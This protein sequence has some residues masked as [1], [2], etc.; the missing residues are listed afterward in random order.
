MLVCS[1][2]SKPDG[3]TQFQIASL[4]KFRIPIT[5]AT[6]LFYMILP[7]ACR[8]RLYEPPATSRILYYTR[9]ALNVVPRLPPHHLQ[10]VCQQPPVYVY[11]YNLIC[12]VTRTLRRLGSRVFL[13]ILG[14]LHKHA[15]NDTARRIY[16]GQRTRG[17][18]SSR[19]GII[20]NGG[21][22]RCCSRR[23]DACR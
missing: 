11:V 14:R 3:A 20:R 12:I 17:M 9:N 18:G 6:R 4:P 10:F 15:P 19:K 23:V 5:P 16:S 8:A 21:T 7:H 1:I 13:G 2:W 22:C